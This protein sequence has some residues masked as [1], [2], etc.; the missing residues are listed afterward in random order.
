MTPAFYVIYGIVLTLLSVGLL[1]F[2]AMAYYLAGSVKEFNAAVADLALALHGLPQNLHGLSPAMAKLADGVVAHERQVF[3]LVGVI[4]EANKN[5]PIEK[6]PE[7][8][9][10]GKDV[11]FDV[12]I[13]QSPFEENE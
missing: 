6:A 11:N 12:H 4:T 13:P 10:N 3:G 5:G 7:F 1:Y 2:G 8:D 9:P